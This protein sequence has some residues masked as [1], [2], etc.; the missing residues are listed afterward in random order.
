MKPMQRK[1][2][3]HDSSRPGGNRRP[4]ATVPPRKRRRPRPPAPQPTSVAQSTS[5]WKPVCPTAQRAHEAELF[6]ELE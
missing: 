1:R 3:Q 6:A 5:A 2:T 4:E